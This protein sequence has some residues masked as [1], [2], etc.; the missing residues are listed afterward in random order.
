MQ[1]LHMPPPLDDIEPLDYCMLLGVIFQ[2]VSVIAN[3][4][5]ISRFLYALP[6]WEGSC[7]WNLS[8]EL[9]FVRRL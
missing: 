1:Y 7:L 6:A 2:S 3:A 8:T 4:V 5:I 9:M